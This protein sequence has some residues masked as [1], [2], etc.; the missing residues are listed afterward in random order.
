[1]DLLT[2]KQSFHLGTAA[3]KGGVKRRGWG[4][5]GGGSVGWGGVREW[6][7]PCPWQQAACSHVLVQ[8]APLAPWNGE[9][10]HRL[11]N[12]VNYHLVTPRHYRQPEN[13]D[14]G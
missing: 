3:T 9:L 10:A 4:G 14:C 8:L 13:T 1:M 11:E 5:E 6:A 2:C 12:K 7:F